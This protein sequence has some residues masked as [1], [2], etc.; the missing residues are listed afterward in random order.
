MVE[1]YPRERLG[2]DDLIKFHNTIFAVVGI[3][4]RKADC[5]AGQRCFEFA[6][7]FVI[8]FVLPHYFPSSVISHDPPRYADLLLPLLFSSFSTPK[9]PP[10]LVAG[11]LAVPVRS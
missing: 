5:R 9:I 8:V 3:F 2:I 4:A 10:R 6:S 7:N 1:K 11:G